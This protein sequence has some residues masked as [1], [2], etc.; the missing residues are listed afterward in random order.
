[1]METTARIDASGRLLV[2]IRVRR[3][4][5]LKPNVDL[6]LTVQNGELRVHTREWAIKQARE[7]L[8]RL[9]RPGQ[10]VVDEFLAER[11]EEARKER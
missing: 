5:G 9:K 4:L 1:M 2:P 3:E 7:R 10:S 11:R 6:V 8:M